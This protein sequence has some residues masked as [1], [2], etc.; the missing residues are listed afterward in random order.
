[1][2]GRDWGFERGKIRREG[3]ICERPVTRSGCWPTQ[4]R[5]THTTPLRVGPSVCRHAACCLLPL[6]LH[7]C[8]QQARRAPAGALGLGVPQQRATPRCAAPG[9]LGRS[10]CARAHMGPRNGEKAKLARHRPIPTQA[11][12]P[13]CHS[14]LASLMGGSLGCG[15]GPA[16]PRAASACF[17][18]FDVDAPLPCSPCPRRAPC[19]SWVAR[20]LGLAPGAGT[21][22]F[23][24]SSTFGPS[25]ARPSPPFS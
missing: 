17:V 25:P 3:T 20:R 5:I 14:P 22:A 12:C 16:A 10:E 1:V 11:L 18:P 2:R 23:F 13:W 4:L 9:C 15:S 8:M 6:C 19:T 21:G 24:W 7:A